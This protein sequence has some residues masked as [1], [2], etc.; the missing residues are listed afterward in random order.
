MEQRIVIERLGHLGDGVAHGP[1]FATR[2]LPGEVVEGV[3]TGDRMADPKIVTPSPDRVKPPCPHYNQCGGCSL[4][5]ARDDFVAA[6]KQ[7]VV[8]TALAAQGL[9]APLR[10]IQTSPPRSRRRATLAGTRTKKGALVGFHA[11]RSDTIVPITDC[12][13]LHPRL[14]AAVPL[15]EEITRLGG[16]R[17]GVLSFS[18][19]LSDEGLDCAVGGGKPLDA[20]LQTV[21]PQFSDRLARLT[22]N[23]ETAFTVA[24][25]TQVMGNARVT[26]PPGAFLQ[27]TIE[28]EAALLAAVGDAVAGATAIVDLFAGCGT[29]TLPLA[30]SAPVHA[31]ESEADMLAA[32]DHGARFATG[33]K[34]ITIETRDLFR[35]PLLPD[36]LKRFDAAIIDPPRAGAEAQVAEIARAQT[37]RIAMVSCNPATFARDAKVLI[38]AG[39]RLNWVQVVDQFRWSPHVELAAS[40]TL[41]HIDAK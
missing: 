32:L 30:M 39:Y 1:V 3:I 12:H 34:R 8:R 2:T 36:E 23:G 19:T 33:Q 26:P 11:A 22:W 35:R 24:S 13:I 4:Q 18:L 16:S 29:F 5:H 9:T 41:P 17:T 28:G 10:P 40:L 7:D 14:M 38:D 31:V 6:W 20:T 37:P 27:A 25:P 15:L 21:L